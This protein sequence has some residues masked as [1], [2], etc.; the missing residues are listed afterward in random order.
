[1]WGVK[2]RYRWD[3]KPHLA[4]RKDTQEKIKQSSGDIDGIATCD[5]CEDRY[6]DE[7]RKLKKEHWARTKCK[8]ISEYHYK[9]GKTY[10]TG[11]LK[12]K[13]KKDEIGLC[14]T[15]I[16]GALERMLKKRKLRHLFY[17]CTVKIRHGVIRAVTDFEK[18]SEV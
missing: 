15:C 16:C 5:E 8:G 10:G 3:K 4:F 6:Y 12:W 17:D 7:Y 9:K 18:P 2:V 14:G 13:Q 11:I 1:M